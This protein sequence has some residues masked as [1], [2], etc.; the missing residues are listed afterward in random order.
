MRIVRLRGSRIRGIREGGYEV[1]APGG[2]VTAVVGVWE[3]WPVF[4]DN[5]YI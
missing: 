4:A 1:R 2:G 3:I 5:M